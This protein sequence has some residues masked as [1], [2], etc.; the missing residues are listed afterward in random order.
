MS[1]YIGLLSGTSVDGIDAALVK[2]N[3]NSMVLI[4]TH[5]SPYSSELKQALQSIIK[6]QNTSLQQLSDIDVK[7]AHEFSKT[8]NQLLK[9]AKINLSDI[10]AIGSHGQTIFHQP[11]GGL[12]N[13]L[14]IGSPHVLAALTGIDVVSNFRNIDMAFEGQGAPLAPVIHEVLYAKEDSNTAIINLGG[15]ANISLV[16]KDYP[17]AKGF[18]TGPANCLI[19]EWINIH[20]NQAYD[21]NGQWAQHGQLHKPLL[22]AMLNDNYF[23]KS[24]P[25]S[26]GR[27]Y[28]NL[29]WVNKHLE[30]HQNINPAH[31]PAD[32]QNTLT[33]LTAHSIADAINT[34]DYS[35]N[36]ILLVGGGAHNDYLRHLIQEYTLINTSVDEQSDW[37]EAILFAYLAERRINNKPLNLA[38]IT[39]ANSALLYGDIVS[40]PH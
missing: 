19:D 22:A 6:T 16:G 2:I 8:V 13:T 24:P 30:S 7:C 14:Q 18:D 9:K 32:I 33:H 3:E 15:I 39:G 20:K 34:E 28:F 38:A 36:E 12:A 11:E 26:T 23:H 10:I 31:N 29:N 4:E 27:E 35:I 1:Y 17:Q 37:I 21:K 5:E 25:K 40:V